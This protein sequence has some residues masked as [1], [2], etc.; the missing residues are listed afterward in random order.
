MNRNIIH[1]ISHYCQ[2]LISG[3]FTIISSKKGVNLSLKLSNHVKK[4]TMQYKSSSFTN[5]R[6]G[7]RVRKPKFRQMDWKPLG[8]PSANWDEAQF[9]GSIWSGTHKKYAQVIVLFQK[10]FKKKSH[11]SCDVA[12]LTNL[13]PNHE[14]QVKEENYKVQKKQK[15]DKETEKMEDYFHPPPLHT[16]PNIFFS[17]K[18]GIFLR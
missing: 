11:T 5:T 15:E 2:F 16:P 17:E 3:S 13:T 6:K 18:H 1:P 14:K 8:S 7:R 12:Q 10:K 4:L 9:G